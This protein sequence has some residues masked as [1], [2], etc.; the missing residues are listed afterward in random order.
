M[1]RRLRTEDISK[2]AEI[3]LRGSLQAHDFVAAAYWQKMK[4]SVIRDYLPR[5][6]TYVFVDRHQIK[7]FISLPEKNYIGALFVDPVYQ[8][9]RIGSKLLEYVRRK[10][11][12]LKLQ[13]YC[14]NSGAQKFY[15]SR[16]F[17]SLKEQSDDSTGEKE[18]IMCWAKGSKNI[19]R[20][21]GDS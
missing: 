15:R 8:R 6:E 11:P 17:Q 12:E 16:G 19:M 13:V 4:P 3:W 1:I 7:G 10:R 21:R 14:R 9:Q 2:A 5:A 20:R 18:L